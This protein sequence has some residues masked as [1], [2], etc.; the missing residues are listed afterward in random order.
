GLAV[1]TEVLRSRRHIEMVREVL[2][3]GHDLMIK[4]AEPNENV[5]FGSTDM[6]LLRTC[7]CPVWLVKPDQG[8]PPFSKILAAVDPAPP[9]DET[10]LLHIKGDIAPKDP[11]LDSKILEL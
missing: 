10:D 7:P 1:S 2:R 11:A 5:L 4:E 6:H 9:P 8:D 3:G